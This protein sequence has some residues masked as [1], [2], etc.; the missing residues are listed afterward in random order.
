MA[1]WVGRGLA[2]LFHDRV[3]RR[4]W[5]VSS[6]PRPYFTPGKDRVPIVQETVW[7]PGP[8]WTG[9]KSRPTGIRSPDRPARSKSLYRLRYPAQPLLQYT[10][11][12]PEN[13]SRTTFLQHADWGSTVRCEPHCRILS[14]SQWYTVRTT[15]S[16]LCQLASQWHTVRTALSTLPVRFTVI[17][18]AWRADLVHF[19]LQ[20]T[21]NNAASFQDSRTMDF[22]YCGRVT[23][24]S[25]WEDIVLRAPYPSHFPFY[26]MFFVWQ[27]K[28]AF[29]NGLDSRMHSACHLGTARMTGGWQWRSKLHAYQ[30]QCTET[31]DIYA[32]S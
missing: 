5:V 3:T 21:Q 10:A 2:L 22:P 24:P 13:S 20:K 29:R 12:I 15:L 17:H 8:V 7:A 4:G 6:T 31:M 18:C 25:C 30:S 28:Y 32:R 16:A 11:A 26:T 19:C 1:Q 14:A 27:E 23:A 9:G